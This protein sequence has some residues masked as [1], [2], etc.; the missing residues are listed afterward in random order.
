MVLYNFG[1][2]TILALGGLTMGLA[3]FAEEL[4]TTEVNARTKAAWAFKRPESILPPKVDNPDWQ[5]NG[6]DAFVYERLRKAGLQP[7]IPASRQVLIRRAHYDL[8]GLPPSLAEVEAFVA[9]SSPEA[10]EKVIDKLL[11]SD[12]YGEK[13]GRHWLDLVR[14][15]ET[16]GYERD[17]RKDLIWKYRDY[18]I[19]AFNQ[20]KPYDRFIME[21][22]AGDELSD[23]DADSITATGFYRLGIWD[24]EPADRELARYD[25]LDDIIRT[26]GETFLGITIGCARCHDHKVDPVTQKD[27][28]SLL[29]FFSD[30]SPHGKGNRNHLPI[31]DPVDKAAFDMAIAEKQ[32]HEANLKAKIVPIEA[33]FMVGLAKRKPKLNL[34]SGTVKG[35]KALRVVPDATRGRGI[36]WDFTFDEPAENW[37]EI[38]FDDSKWRKGRS[39][40]GSPGTPSSKVRTP[41]HSKNIWMRRDFR[42]D[43]IPGKLTLKIHH[44]ESAEI[45]LNGKQI[46]TF[47]GY[48]K[49][50]TEVDVTSECLDVLQ[51]GR[52]TIAVHCMHTSG[53]Q[54]IDVGLVVDQSTTPLPYLASKYGRDVLGEAK[55]AEYNKLRNE[56]S[57]VQSIKLTPKV[58]YAMAVAE[59]ARRKMWILRRGLPAMK[60]AE[61]GP[62]YPEILAGS[63]VDI[64]EDYAVA[65]SSGKRRVLAEWLASTEN[66]MTSRVMANRLWQHHFG[67][68][69]VRS[70]NNFGFVGAQPTHPGLLNWLANELPASGWRLK[71][72]HKLIM[73]SNTYQMSSKGSEVALA[74]D[75]NNDLMWRYD[76]RRLSA[77]EIR[78]SILNLTGQLNLKMGGPSIYTEVPK[79]VLATASRPDAA[80]GRSSD[81]DRNRR[82]VYIYVKRSLREPFLN[83]FDWADTDNTC[84]VRFVTT[85]PTQTLTLLNSKFLNDSAA[86][87]AKRLTR[88]ESTEAKTQVAQALHLATRR[89]PTAVEIDD[90][91]R[92]IQNLKAKATL[93]DSQ[94]LQ[95]F[96]LLVLNLNEFLYL[97]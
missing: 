60:T 4:P 72:M 44:D 53:G 97:D 45:Y 69:I 70:S 77:E 29:A 34:T 84:D 59:D 36:E 21:Q 9:D 10:F 46:K 38:A 80:W 25:Y 42:L 88:A 64:P 18:V 15:A 91:L 92:L 90:G 22:L 40:F 39:G 6:I 96:C 17:S 65:K 93:D 24:D 8:T 82:S 26:V 51:T 78:D 57:K 66:P 89:T 73:M 61:V 32:K 3:G 50:Y 54:Y 87:F 86:S 68:G 12:R 28:Y 79:D 49:Q 56:L 47:K 5:G 13:W 48:L 71:R 67:R 52:N 35:K 94:A 75:P 95:R 33:E 83:A 1:S 43:R 7:T 14:F 58:E 81:E 63:T 19:R 31:S 20:D 74:K 27:Y 41:W 85:V 62:A 23:R 2:K 30:I 16:N 55:L 76:M 11:S 37:F